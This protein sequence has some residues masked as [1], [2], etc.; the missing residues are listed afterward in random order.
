MVIG[1]QV[2]THGCVHFCSFLTH[3]VTLFTVTFP[4]V[5]TFWMLIFQHSSGPD[6][7]FLQGSFWILFNNNTDIFSLNL[8]CDAS[9]SPCFSWTFSLCSLLP[10]PH[11]WPS[12]AEMIQMF[13]ES[14]HHLLMHSMKCDQGGML[15]VLGITWKDFIIPLILK[16]TLN[17]GGFLSLYFKYIFCKH[18]CCF[19][20]LL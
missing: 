16:G 13:T 11:L 2:G 6:F 1:R 15:A 10:C 20:C 8:F 7:F 9:C 19:W 4:W 18:N 17:W 5:N 3:T 12:V 14:R